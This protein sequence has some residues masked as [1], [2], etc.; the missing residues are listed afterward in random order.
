M[1][2]Y[3]DTLSRLIRATKWSLMNMVT[4]NTGF[5]TSHGWDESEYLAVAVQ[6]RHYWT[7]LPPKG[8]PSLV[9]IF[10]TLLVTIQGAQ[11]VLFVISNASTS[12]N[13]HLLAMAEGLGVNATFIPVTILGIL[14]LF[15]A[16]RLSDDHEFAMSGEATPSEQEAMELMP[17]T[18]YMDIDRNWAKME[19][20]GLY[21]TTASWVVRLLRLFLVAF[22][23]SLWFTLFLYLMLSSSDDV[24]PASNFTMIL[25]YLFL[26]GSSVFI[27]GC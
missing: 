21:R 11:G 7:R 26:V 17:I 10:Q 9:S 4:A 16:L 12:P 22:L 15:P 18:E 25:L 24:A 8:F 14:R 1:W 19:S 27:F 13:L 20:K 2:R 6:R 5:W 3:Y 23:A